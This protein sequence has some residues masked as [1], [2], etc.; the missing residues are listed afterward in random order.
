MQKPASFASVKNAFFFLIKFVVF[1]EVSSFYLDT[2]V[3][4]EGM[5]TTVNVD[6]SPNVS[7]MGGIVIEA[8]DTF[9]LRPFLDTRTYENLWARRSGVFHV[10]DDSEMIARSAIGKLETLPRLI[11]AETVEG[12]V[13]ADACR[14]YEF[15][16]V[17]VINDSKRSSI[18]C[19]TRHQRFGREF[20]GFN[21]AKH[22][23]LEAAILATRLDWIAH[24]EVHCSFR[25]YRSIVE[26]TAGPAEQR[27]FELL[28]NFVK[29][30]DHPPAGNSKS[31]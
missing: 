19:R 1:V 16:V 24:D 8:F 6:G 20:F 3:I 27:A 28:E 21:R 12:W 14:W 18:Q 31:L 2:N 11:R 29:E 13:I 17:S 9:E 4:L 15:D 10:T 26:K 5:V 22:A 23:V 30:Y 7:A 25:Q